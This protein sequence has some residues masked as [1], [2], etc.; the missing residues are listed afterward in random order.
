ML[1]KKLQPEPVIQARDTQLLS[2]LL[3]SRVMTREQLAKLYFAGNY[4]V[5]KKRLQ[6]LTK[7][8][9]V[10]E[11]KTEANPGHFFPSMMS[12]GRKGFDAISDTPYL[13]A[14]TGMKWEHLVE[15]VQL[16]RSTLAHELE[17]VDHK[18][19]FT[20]ALHGHRSLA[21]GEFLTWPALYQFTT[22]DW[23]T[24]KPFVLKPDAQIVALEAGELE[25]NFFLEY[26]RSKEAGRHLMKKAWGYH[27]Y[28]A[29]GGFAVRNGAAKDAFKE[30]PFRVLYILPSIERRNSIAERLLQICDPGNQGAKKPLLLKNQHWLT[31]SEEFLADPL[32]AIWLTLS[33]YWQATEGTAYDPRSYFTTHRITPRDRLVAEATNLQSL[34]S[35][36]N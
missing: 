23:E 13:A 10:H 21:L 29:S 28:Y 31:T 15:R 34:F 6:K 1:N 25:H 18:V 33:G 2:G 5:A 32:G 11:R 30:H 20:Q 22:E 7:G 19:A 26:D 27:R 12:L 3:E 9:F 14:F 17:L 4:D 24:G 35:E 8:G 36:E 16:A